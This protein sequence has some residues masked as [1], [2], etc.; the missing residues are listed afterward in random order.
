[1]LFDS[2]KGP[3]EEEKQEG[4]TY[5]NEA[6][7]ISRINFETVC[8]EMGWKRIEKSKLQKTIDGLYKSSLKARNLG[9]VEDAN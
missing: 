8:F 1:M 7:K 2:L 4:V 9:N 5:P 3:T 6:G